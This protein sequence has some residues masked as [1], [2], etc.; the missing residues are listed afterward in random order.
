MGDVLA[1]WGV[2][3]FVGKW[4]FIGLI[5]LALVIILGAVR[6]EARGR[7]PG[8][9]QPTAVPGRLRVLQAGGAAQ[10]LAG[11][12]FE[13]QPVTTLGAADA[14]TLVLADPYVSGRHARLAWDGAEW[15]LEDLG[16]ANGTLVNGQPCR[17][18]RRC[19]VPFGARIGAGGVVL[20]LVE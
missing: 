13:L 17:P 4:I 10:L 14:N 18:H 7:V 12:A 5:Y 9:V 2:L 1:L 16:S 20:E 19:R 11:R 15:W 6:A 8:A 3:L